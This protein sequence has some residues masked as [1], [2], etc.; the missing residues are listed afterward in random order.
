MDYLKPQVV[1]IPAD[2]ALG[3]TVRLTEDEPSW[4]EMKRFI[5]RG[6]TS[7]RGV[8]L[9]HVN[10]LAPDMTAAHMF[11]DEEGLIKGLVPN[12]RATKHYHRASLQ[13]GVHPTSLT[14]FIA[15][16]AI[17]IIGIAVEG[18]DYVQQT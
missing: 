13:H 14:G 18:Y 15:G 1:F 10:V 6:Q 8:Y 3:L 9:E 2:P 16:N 17:L 5:A 11:V 7:D 12:P 4:D